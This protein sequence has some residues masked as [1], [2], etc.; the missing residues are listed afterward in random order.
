MI[1]KA[2]FLSLRTLYYS[3][4][5]S[6]CNVSTITLEFLS[7][8]YAD[9]VDSF[10]G[11]GVVTAASTHTLKCFYRYVR[12]GDKMREKEGVKIG[13]ELVIYISSIDLKVATGSEYLPAAMLTALQKMRITFLGQRFEIMEVTPWEPMEL[14]DDGLACVTYQFSLKHIV[15]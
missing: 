12:G 3:K 8:Q 9:P 6:C 7:V 14:V 13:T 5:S 10:M 1:S 2:Q 4:I 15:L 11:E